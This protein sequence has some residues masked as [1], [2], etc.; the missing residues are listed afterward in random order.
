LVPS[1]YNSGE[2]TITGPITHQGPAW[3]RWALITAA[4]ALTRS[5]SPLGKRYW[6]LRRRSKHPNVAKTAVACSVARCVYGVLKHGAPFQAERWG[7]RAGKL[8]Q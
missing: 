8:G 4:N 1:L 7:R 6:G 2:V 5:R 3:L